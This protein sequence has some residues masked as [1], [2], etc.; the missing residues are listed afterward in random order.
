MKRLLSLLVLLFAMSAPAQTW[1]NYIDNVVVSN[2]VVTADWGGYGLGVVTS[3]FDGEGIRITSPI[4]PVIWFEQLGTGAHVHVGPSFFYYGD[5]TFGVG[6]PE[7]DGFWFGDQ[8]MILGNLT[9][10]GSM[11]GNT[12]TNIVPAGFPAT[13]SPPGF[14]AHNGTK[15]YWGTGGGTN[16]TTGLTTN[17]CTIFC[18]G[19]TNTLS[20]TNG[21]LAGISPSV[22]H[23]S[24]L[25]LPGGGYLIQP[26]GG[27]LCLP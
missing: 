18:D 25:I 27:T 9:I 14:L 2:L 3:T 13:N 6:K 26:S 1:T 16:T 7:F 22:V 5:G 21:L 8:V 4:R 23:C 17:I 20:F 12:I 24:S 15:W 10:G 19:T 11:N